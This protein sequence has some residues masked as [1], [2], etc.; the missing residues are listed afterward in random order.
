MHQA[1]G[2][3][4]GLGTVG[5]VFE[6]LD[7]GGVGFGNAVV[8]HKQGSWGLDEGQFLKSK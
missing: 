6:Q 2:D 7:E 4:V 8:G 3:A 1:D 5:G